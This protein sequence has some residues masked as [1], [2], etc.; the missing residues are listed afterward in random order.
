MFVLQNNQMPDVVPAG[1]TLE[2]FGSAG[3]GTAKFDLS[4]A[5][6]ETPD[7]FV[8]SIEYAADLFDVATIDG[9]IGLFQSI[10][11]DVVADPGRRVSDLDLAPADD[12]RALASWN[13]SGNSPWMTD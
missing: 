4:L 5:M 3:A 7:G 2:P 12:L 8:G 10:L 1:L 9:W 6:A 11:N 13:A